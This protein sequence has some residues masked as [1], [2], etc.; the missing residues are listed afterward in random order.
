MLRICLC[1]NCYSCALPFCSCKEKFCMNQTLFVNYRGDSR[2][3]S[4][5]ELLSYLAHRQRLLVTV[6]KLPSAIQR[7]QEQMQKLDNTLMSFSIN[8]ICLFP[9]TNDIVNMLQSPHLNP[10]SPRKRGAAKLARTTKRYASVRTQM[11]TL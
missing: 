2:S 9:A 6:V 3:N 5:Q 8:L 1:G 11:R 4:K 10:H 7:K